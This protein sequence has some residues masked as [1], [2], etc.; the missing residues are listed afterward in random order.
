MAE[1][2]SRGVGGW[3]ERQGGSLGRCN[4][5]LKMPETPKAWDQGANDRAEESGVFSHT[6]CCNGSPPVPMPKAAAWPAWHGTC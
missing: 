3:G 6:G 5:H 4:S 1:H 2:L